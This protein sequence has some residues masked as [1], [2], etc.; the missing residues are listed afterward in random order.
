[1]AIKFEDTSV[2]PYVNNLQCQKHLKQSLCQRSTRCMTHFI[3]SVNQKNTFS[4]LLQSVHCVLR[5]EAATHQHYIFLHMPR[6][7]HFYFFGVCVCRMYKVIPT[8]YHQ[9][10]ATVICEL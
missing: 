8:K 9:Q 10:Y 2:L 1:M 6:N 5:T 3:I 7:R 4:Q